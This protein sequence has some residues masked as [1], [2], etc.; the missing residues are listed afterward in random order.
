MRTAYQ[1]YETLIMSSEYTFTY[2]L[3]YLIQL[4]EDKSMYMRLYLAHCYIISHVGIIGSCLGSAH[5]V[6]LP[7]RG[8]LSWDVPI[9][10][11]FP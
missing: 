8:G 11:V 9:D 5:I 7:S 1:Y 10:R 2:N 4:A 6:L 3:F